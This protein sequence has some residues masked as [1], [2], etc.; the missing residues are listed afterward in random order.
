VWITAQLLRGRTLLVIGCAIICANALAALLA[1][2][3]Q[4]R[5]R[6]QADV[7]LAELLAA[8]CAPYLPADIAAADAGR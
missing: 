5:D 4:R 7:T 6:Q 3:R 2:E 1:E 8:T